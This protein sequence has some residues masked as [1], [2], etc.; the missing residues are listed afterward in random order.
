MMLWIMTTLHGVGMNFS[1]DELME[2]HPDEVRA[3]T[4]HQEH[5]W[6]T[7]FPKK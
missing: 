2:M 3:V 6:S 4:A 1:W 7:V 5:L